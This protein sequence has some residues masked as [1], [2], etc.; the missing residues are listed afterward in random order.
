MRLKNFLFTI[1]FLVCAFQIS[2]F[3]ESK[4]KPNY[5]FDGSISREVLENYLEKSITAMSLAV[6]PKYSPEG[7]YPRKDLDLQFIK[8]VGAKFVGRAIYRWGKEDALNDPEF[9]SFA[10]D[11]IA[12]IHEIDP[13]IIVQACAFEAVYPEVSKV[14]IP[15]WVFLEMGLV[16]QKRNFKYEDMLFEDDLFVGHWGGRGSV[17]DITRLETQLW[18]VYLIGSYIDLGV[19]AIHLGQVKL[20]GAKDPSL[21]TWAQFVEKLRKLADKKARR[22][23]VLFDA[24]TPD[25]SMLY[26]GVSLLDFN[27]FPLRIKEVDLDKPEKMRGVLEVGHTDALYCRSAGCKTPNGWE[28]ESLPYLVEFDNF[29]ISNHAGVANLADHFIWGY[30]EISW[31]YLQPENERK[32]W[33]KYAYNWLKNTDQNGHLQMPTSRVITLKKNQTKS[34]I[35]RVLNKSEEI[36]TGMNLEG[37]IKEIFA[38]Q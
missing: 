7:E 34:Q 6:H 36:P 29:G 15:E 19:E 25:G 11:L 22:H 10:K 38:N 1:S 18:F 32:E 27:S 28:C 3:A 31:L 12:K 24:H 21:K 37:T 16:P 2:L 35:S 8:N 30:D 26:K 23:K 4:A 9:F 17:P 20:M 13:E 5:A 33:L 14:E